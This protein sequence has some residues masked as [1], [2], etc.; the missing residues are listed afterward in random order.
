[1]D[2]IEG[3]SPSS[4]MKSRVQV[5]Q[6]KGSSPSSQGFKSL[7]SRVQVPQVEGSSPSSQGFK[8]LKSRVQVPPYCMNV[9][10]PQGPNGKYG[11]LRFMRYNSDDQA[12][13]TY[14][15]NPMVVAGVVTGNFVMAL[16]HV[17]PQLA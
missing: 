15:E 9:T 5:P 12:A 7:K 14:I 2:R 16:L 3:L 11:T 4:P 13:G 1:M 17:W 8:S 6:V 10:F